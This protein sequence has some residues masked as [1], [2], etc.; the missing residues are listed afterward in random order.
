MLQNTPPTYLFI[1]KA[2]SKNF[3]NGNKL[4]E[5]CR[6]TQENDLAVCEV[7]N[8]ISMKCL[9]FF[10]KLVTEPSRAAFHMFLPVVFVVVLVNI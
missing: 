3:F 9:Q 4:Q 8:V 2:K 6:Q 7:E 10:F 5:N 1:A